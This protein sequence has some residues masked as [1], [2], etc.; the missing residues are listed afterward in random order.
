[1]ARNTTARKMTALEI[2]GELLR[3]IDL[4]DLDEIG[5]V[6]GI[7]GS[8]ISKWK[9]DGNPTKIER[10]SRFLFAVGL[11]VVPQDAV[12][13]DM[14]H[15]DTVFDLAA[16]GLAAEKERMLDILDK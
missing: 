2:E 12:F 14:D 15:L 7:T 5:E 8:A 3:A 11:K 1:M 13:M 16:K 10:F 6:V 4:N 9:T